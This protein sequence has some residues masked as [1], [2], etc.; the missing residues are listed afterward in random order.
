MVSERPV[1]SFRR[2]RRV[3]FVGEQWGGSNAASVERALRRAGHIVAVVDPQVLRLDNDPPF[4]LR[5]ARRLLRRW[6]LEEVGRQVVMT[7]KSFAADLMVVYKGNLLPRWALEAVKAR[8]V[9]CFNVWP[10]VSVTVHG[11]EIPECLPLYDR[12]FT[13]KSFGPRDLR[14]LG[15]TTPTEF[16]PD[17]YDPDL[18]RMVTPQESDLAT[19]GCDASFIGTWSPKKTQY[20][21]TVVERA[22]E[23]RL[24]VWGTQWASRANSLGKLAGALE[25]HSVVGDLY[26]LAIACTA[27]NLGLLSEIRPGASSGDLTTSRTFEIPA[28]GGFMLHERTDEVLTFFTEGTEIA[29]F[30]DEAEMVEKIR[31]YLAHPQER[32]KMRWAAHERCVAEYSVDAVVEGIIRRYEEDRGR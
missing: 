32:D 13:T 10:D 1:T 15:I 31:Y 20:L 27:V 8:G 26:A 16:M 7:A 29:C 9:Y 22:P 28:C 30:A 6:L 4:H 14:A 3:L 5:V 24:R 2:S 11:S 19:M 17:V 18:E 23:V 25:G 21:R 12:I